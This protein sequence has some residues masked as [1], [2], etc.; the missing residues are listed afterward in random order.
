MGTGEKARLPVV[1]AGEFTVPVYGCDH[2]CD[3]RCQDNEAYS[4]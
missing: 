4:P 2:W 3:E 1:L